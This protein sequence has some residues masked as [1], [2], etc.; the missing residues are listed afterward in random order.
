[1]NNKIITD[2]S[3]VGG[4]LTGSIIALSLAQYGI[5]S[6]IIEKNKNQLMLN[7]NYDT[8]TTALAPSSKDLL[9]SINI[10]ESLKQ[11]IGFINEI[12]VS[13]GDSPL[14]LHFDKHDIGDKTLGFMIK[15]SVLRIKINTA[16]L[17]D[18]HITLISPATV[19]NI[20]INNDTTVLSLNNG[21]EVNSDLIIGADGKN[22][23]IRNKSNIN[24]IGWEYNQTAIITNIKHD[25]SHNNIAHERFL[26]SGPLAILPLK[27]SFSSSIVWTESTKNASSFLTLN[28]EDF[29]N[30]L[31]TRIGSFLGKIY[32]YENRF[33]YPLIL[34]IAKNYISDRVVLIGDAAHTIHPIAGQGLNLG[35]RDIKTLA[36]ILANAKKYGLDLGSKSILNEY[37][38][39]RR[40]ENLLMG[41]TTDFLNN[42]FSSDAPPVKLVRDLGLNFINNLSSLK[43]QFIHHAIGK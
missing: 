25:L 21:I 18:K 43:E 3:I 42:L 23:S 6:S 33:S 11:D 24:T 39:I 8:R 10:W 26:K 22:S 17:N 27:N 14:F 1:M 16:I 5:T 31:A 36:K 40:S 38:K 41:I 4:G 28:K 12:R 32:L 2:V 30:E 37:Q 35:I 9:S 7:K 20:S 13:D 34:K 19:E 29:E 15:N